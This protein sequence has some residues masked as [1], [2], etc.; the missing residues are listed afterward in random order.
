MHF[1]WLWSSR[2]LGL[3]GTWGRTERQPWQAEE[4][5]SCSD[6]WWAAL[7]AGLVLPDPWGEDRHLQI[8]AYQSGSPSE[9]GCTNK[10]VQNCIAR[11]SKGFGCFRKSWAK[12]MRRVSQTLSRGRGGKS[13]RWWWRPGMGISYFGRGPCTSCLQKRS[14]HKTLCVPSAGWFSQGFLC[15]LW[16]QLGLWQF[17]VLQGCLLCLYLVGLTVQQ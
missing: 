14:C 12:L 6:L 3:G 16:W 4:I 9:G 10:R 15:L 5:R 8:G 1:L 2:V 17:I 11:L 7:R 13:C